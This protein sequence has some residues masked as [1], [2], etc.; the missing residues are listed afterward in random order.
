[1]SD[2]KL[3]FKLR[4]KGV[5]ADERRFAEQIAK[6]LVGDF[7]IGRMT[8]ATQFAATPFARLGAITPLF[9]V[10]MWH[11][12]LACIGR[13]YEAAIRS[14]AA[15]N[16]SAFAFYGDGCAAGRAIRAALHNVGE[17]PDEM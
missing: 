3:Q 2:E 17:V 10:E 7:R 5:P 12:E 9:P 16:L 14:A 1:M 4:D 13:C 15:L 6:S 11:E 8:D